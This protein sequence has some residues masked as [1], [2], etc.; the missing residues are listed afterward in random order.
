MAGWLILTERCSETTG[1]AIHWYR[2]N[3]IAILHSL[4]VTVCPM[5]LDKLSR[6]VAHPIGAAG[7]M[8]M[9][10]RFDLEW[11]MGSL[12]MRGHYICE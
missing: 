7:C 2:L 5:F 10:S 4:T 3:R 1:L 9:P 8:P 6:P 12:A 11:Q